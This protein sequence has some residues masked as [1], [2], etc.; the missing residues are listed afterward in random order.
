MI[1]KEILF[2]Q[3]IFNIKDLDNLSG[4]LKDDS[5]LI[6]PDLSRCLLH[7]KLQML[8]CCIRKKLD[9][10]RVEVDVYSERLSQNRTNDNDDEDDDDADFYDCEEDDTFLSKEKETSAV[11]KDNKCPNNEP[12]VKG[13]PEGRIKKFGNLTLMNNS[14]E[15]IYIPVCQDST[16]MTEDMLEQHASVLVNL[17]MGDDAAILRAK[18]QSASLISDMQSFKVI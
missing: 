18:I 9:R 1:K 15:A 17:G 11:I 16:P 3:N 13:T 2:D 14:K 4:P 5:T 7:Q 6:P 10:Q 8:N 12:I